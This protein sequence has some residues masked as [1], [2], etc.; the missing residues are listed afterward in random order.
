MPAWLVGFVTHWG[1]R[2]GI[3]ALLTSTIWLGGFTMYRGIV[4]KAYN[5]GYQKALTDHPQNVYNGPSVINQGRAM[6]AF[7]FKFGRHWALGICHD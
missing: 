7:P 5:Q 4:N 1:V 3:V 6:W 2:M